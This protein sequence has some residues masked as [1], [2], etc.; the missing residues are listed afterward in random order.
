[1][2]NIKNIIKGGLPK[3]KRQWKV[4][5]TCV[6]I[7]TILWGLLKFSEERNDNL[8]V[9]LNFY[10]FPSKKI[11]I[12]E[13]PKSI[14]VTIQAQGFELISK[15]FGF[16]NPSVDIDLSKAKVLKRNN[17][18]HY[19]WLPSQHTVELEEATGSKLKGGKVT[20]KTDTV[21]II[22]SDVVEKDLVTFFKY[23]IT[24]AEDLFVFK[25]PLLSPY[26]VT[27]RG[28][29]SVLNALDSIST[30]PVRL[31]LLESDLDEDFKLLMPFGVDSLFT[32]S[33]RVF[34][35][36]EALKEHEFM[37]PI[38][39]LDAPDSLEFKLFPS[40]VK[41]SFTCGMSDLAKFTP[42]DFGARVN[43]EDIQSSFKK[44]NVELFKAPDIVKKIKVEPASVEYI[45]K[46]ID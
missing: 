2:A 3:E 18:I 13:I 28:A 46:S 22:F 5:L 23:K 9:D 40:E 42:R 43:F 31:D 24:R 19:F 6:G 7:S 29:K 26:K 11:R 35:G 12:S 39:I 17:E 8:E 10:N 16:R 45:V 1:M 20:S 37:I 30:E 15:S 33:V 36:V 41:V 32:D 4:F 14:S 27:V 44:L 21:K 34:M 38:S 25:E